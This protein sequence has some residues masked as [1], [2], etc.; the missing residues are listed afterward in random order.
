MKKCK[1]CAED[2]QDDA[3]VCRFCHREQFKHQTAGN[4][5]FYTIGVIIAI[6]IGLYGLY[7]DISTLMYFIGPLEGIIVGLIGSPLIVIGIPIFYLINGNWVP[8]VVIYGGGILSY[9][10]TLKNKP[11]NEA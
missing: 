3:V 6:L 2:I 9:V 4:K 7:L 11:D 10:L 1:Y 8:A 5:F